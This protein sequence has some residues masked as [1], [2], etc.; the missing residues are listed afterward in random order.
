MA[1]ALRPG[2]RP[3]IAGPALLLGFGA[4]LQ[5]LL[6]AGAFLANVHGVEEIVRPPYQFWTATAH[7]AAGAALLASAVVL[8]LRARRVPGGAAGPA[9]SRGAAVAAGGA[10]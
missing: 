10:A 8:W 6:G 4:V 1:A 2:G 9:P 3:G 5:V 7:Q